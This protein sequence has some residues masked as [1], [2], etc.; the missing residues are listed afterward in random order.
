MQ[1][2]ASVYTLLLAALILAAGSLGD[3]FGR[4]RLFV[5]GLTILAVASAGAA[6]ARNGTDLI[7][8]RAGQGVGGAPLGPNS[9]ALLSAAFPKPTPGRARAPRPAFTRLPGRGGP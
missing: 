5:L 4:L 6:A 9:P 8:A 1:W 2:I 3:R 7:V